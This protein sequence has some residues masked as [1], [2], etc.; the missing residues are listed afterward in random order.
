MT[1]K[2]NIDGL[3]VAVSQILKDFSEEVQK[4]K[5]EAVDE[6]AA[7]ATKAVKNDAPVKTERYK[8][9][10]KDE[11]TKDTALEY[12]RT[13]H[14][15]G[16]EHRLT[17]Q[18]EYGHAIAGGTGRTKPQEHW[19]KGQEYVEKNFERIFKEKLEGK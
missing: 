5:R 2:T 1:I 11:V 13:T 17:H 6:T 4:A 14:A 12:E 16:G 7:G 19:A 8:K 10:I 15:S 9:S 18:L 3:S